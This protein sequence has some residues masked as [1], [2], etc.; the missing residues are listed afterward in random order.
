MKFF[1]LEKFNESFIE[2]WFSINCHV[3]EEFV[4]FLHEFVN[5]KHFL[6]ER[7]QFLHKIVIFLKM[8][9]WGVWLGL[10]GWRA[11]GLGAGAVGPGGLGGGGGWARGRGAWGWVSASASQRAN[12]HCF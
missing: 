2:I 5:G 11:G 7:V 8:C 12:V 9:F 4:Q 10:G 1:E 3:L 6:H